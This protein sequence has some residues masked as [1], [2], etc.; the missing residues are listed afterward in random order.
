MRE[1]SMP[2]RSP[3]RI[4]GDC[5]VNVAQHMSPACFSLTVLPCRFRED[6]VLR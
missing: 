1:Q 3:C 6:T 5:L 4:P 2:N